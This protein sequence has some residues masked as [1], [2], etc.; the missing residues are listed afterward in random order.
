MKRRL[1]MFLAVLLLVQVMTPV[2]YA[3][4]LNSTNTYN[5]SQNDYSRFG[6]IAEDDGLEYYA[7][8][9]DEMVLSSQISS[10][11][12]IQFSYI[13][14]G[15]DTIYCSPLIDLSEMM[16]MLGV[17]P[18]KS[19]S[20]ETIHKD[21]CESIEQIRG[22]YAFVSVEDNDVAK[23][24][25]ETRGFSTLSAAILDAYGS[26]YSLK[27]IGGASKTYNG[28]TYH[29][30]CRETKSTSYTT[31]DSHWFAKDTAVTALVAWILT[32]GWSWI[33]LA[34]DIILG[35]VTTVLVNGVKQTVNNLTAERSDVSLMH[36][37]L[38]FVDGYSQTQYWAGW[39]RKRYFFKG[40]LGWTYDTGFH[41]TNKH[42]DYDNI[43]LLMDTGFQN[44][45]NYVLN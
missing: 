14:T 40:D 38:V 35:A 22:T 25:D 32:G 34:E 31:P 9:D 18:D 27:L 42:N 29:V 23:M 1:S 13:M 26:N 21:I 5:L 33:A 24:M 4:T 30:K 2:A 20:K 45:V 11:D 6:K 41:F 8:I 16:T 44:F 17:S 3:T 39:T 43:T 15:D 12:M 37:R 36:T 10:D 7:L 19:L 28:V